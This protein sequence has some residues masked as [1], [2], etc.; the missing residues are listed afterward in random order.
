MEHFDYML[1]RV[2][3]ML[4]AVLYITIPHFYLHLCEVLRNCRF[5]K[6]SLLIIQENIDI[7]L[8][9]D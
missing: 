2:V 6:S 7:R 5:N 3:A 4:I 1:V 8:F 9:I